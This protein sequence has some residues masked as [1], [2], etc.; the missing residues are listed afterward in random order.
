MARE[1][2][3]DEAVEDE[4]A[5][6]QASPYV[7]LARREQA[8]RYRRRQFMYQLRAFEKKGMSLEAEGVT[9]E[10]LD[11]LAASGEEVAE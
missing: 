2:L 6:L 10:Y 8:I 7:K 3:T 9:M 1:F 4:I 5:R 11:D